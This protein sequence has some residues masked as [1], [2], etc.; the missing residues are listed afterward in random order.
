MQNENKPVGMTESDDLLSHWRVRASESLELGDA[1]GLD[2]VTF[3][4]GTY[5]LSLPYSTLAY[6]MLDT[7]SKRH[8]ETTDELKVAFGS[9]IVTVWGERLFELQ[10][11][12]ADRSA[13]AVRQSLPSASM[14]ELKRAVI[15]EIKWVEVRSEAE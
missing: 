9:H 8:G 4:D 5:R 15:K 2:Q 12:L 1:G 13:V 6:A 7:N 3:E 14:M 11:A 10:Q